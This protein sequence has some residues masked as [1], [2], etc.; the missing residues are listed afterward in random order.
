MQGNRA[1]IGQL[2]QYVKAERSIESS[3]RILLQEFIKANLLL[4]FFIPR[5]WDLDRV[6]VP[7]IVG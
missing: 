1:R 2:C 3:G 4:L 7:D 6:V 5:H